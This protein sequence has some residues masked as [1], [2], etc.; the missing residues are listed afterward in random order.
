MVDL[1]AE[2]QPT[3]T[4]ELAGRRRPHRLHGSRRRCLA[5]NRELASDHVAKLCSPCAA[6]PDYDPSCDGQFPRKLAEYLTANV[7]RHVDPVAYFGVCDGG[8]RY[9]WWRIQC[10]RRAGWSIRGCPP[11]GGGYIVV[12]KPMA[13]G[14]KLKT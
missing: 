14:G 10:L 2:R 8:R 13:D 9:V 6:R 4:N 7:G 11:P 1:H 3:G 12:T 5:C